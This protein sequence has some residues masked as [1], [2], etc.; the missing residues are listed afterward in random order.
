MIVNTVSSDITGAR[1][2][3]YSNV[4]FLS[5]SPNCGFDCKNPRHLPVFIFQTAPQQSFDD[6]STTET[7]FALKHDTE[8]IAAK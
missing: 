1:F 8:L 3:S 6:V 5:V 2:G 4:H 7:L